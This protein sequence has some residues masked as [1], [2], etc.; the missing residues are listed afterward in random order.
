MA[1]QDADFRAAL[2]MMTTRLNSGNHPGTG[3]DK[4]EEIGGFV[5]LCTALLHRIKNGTGAHTA[6][7]ETLKTIAVEYGI[8][9]Q[10]V[11]F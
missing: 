5:E 6:P 2:K 8:D 11:G 7:L 1:D 4:K 3:Q 9:P 10:E